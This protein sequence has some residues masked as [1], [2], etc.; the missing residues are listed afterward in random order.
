MKVQKL[1]KV[2]KEGFNGCALSNGTPAG[3][4]DPIRV[5]GRSGLSHRYSG[6]LRK[7]FSNGLKLTEVLN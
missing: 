5:E 7:V 6:I 2:K 1:T 4:C 3:E